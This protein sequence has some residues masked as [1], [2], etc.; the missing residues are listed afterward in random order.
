M[1][2][3]QELLARLRVP[4]EPNNDQMMREDLPTGRQACIISH[5]AN[6]SEKPIFNE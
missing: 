3:K 6:K 5:I 4:M 1:K 2:L